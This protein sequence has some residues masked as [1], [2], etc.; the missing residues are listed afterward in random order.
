MANII[1][2]FSKYVLIIFM[3]FY[4]LECFVVFRHATEEV[5]NGIYIRQ[6]ILK[7]GRASCRE[8]V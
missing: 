5:R 1:M 4:T 2:E 7:I 8:R 3:A 6:N